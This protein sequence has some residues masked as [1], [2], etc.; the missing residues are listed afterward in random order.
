MGCA[1]LGLYIVQSDKGEAYYL[2]H[3]YVREMSNLAFAEITPVKIEKNRLVPVWLFEEEADE[4][5]WNPTTR[6]YI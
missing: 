4:W 5:G 6:E 3:T 2:A 1:V